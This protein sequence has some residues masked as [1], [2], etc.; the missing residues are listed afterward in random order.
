LLIPQFLDNS[1]KNDIIFRNV[2]IL[3]KKKFKEEDFEM[4]NRESFFE[5]GRIFYSLQHE[6]RYLRFL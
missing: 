6:Q 3:H 1:N 5:K 4:E 2:E